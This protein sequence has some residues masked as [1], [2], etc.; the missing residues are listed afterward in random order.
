VGAGCS[1]SNENVSRWRTERI[2]SI[3][4]TQEAKEKRRTQKK[5]IPEIICTIN[6]RRRKH[7]INLSAEHIAGDRD[8]C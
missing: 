6:R 3:L 4:E 7:P 8:G 1:D 2:Y 5:Q